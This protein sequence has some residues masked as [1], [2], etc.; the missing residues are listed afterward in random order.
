MLTYSA[1]WGK[2]TRVEYK[3]ITWWDKLDYIGLS[4][5]FPLYEWDSPSLEQLVA[6]WTTYTDHWGGTYHWVDD[7]KA[8]HD[9]FNKDVVFTEIGFGSYINSP[10]RWDQTAEDR[11]TGPRRAGTRR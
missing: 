8:M 2:S 6:G 11:R 5:Y 10:A 4:A 1:N 3:Q 9:R 7:I